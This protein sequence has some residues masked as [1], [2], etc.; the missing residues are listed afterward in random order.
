M[1]GLVFSI[2]PCGSL[3]TVAFVLSVIDSEHRA[4]AD[5]IKA[6]VNVEK[7]QSCRNL[8]KFRQFVKKSS[9]SPAPN[10]L[11]GSIR[12]IFFMMSSDLY[13]SSTIILCFGSSTKL[14]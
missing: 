4:I 10:R 13:P 2:R 5:H 12:D 14:I 1:Y 3:H 9:V 7:F 6:T 11:D 8:R